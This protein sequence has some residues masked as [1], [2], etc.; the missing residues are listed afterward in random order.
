MREEKLPQRCLCPCL[1]LL[2]HPPA[3]PASQP[4][5]RFTRREGGAERRGAAILPPSQDA[6]RNGARRCP[7]SSSP[8]HTLLADEEGSGPPTRSA[9]VRG[10]QGNRQRGQQRKEG[11]RPAR[12]SGLF[13]RRNMPRLPRNGTRRS[14]HFPASSQSQSQSNTTQHTHPSPL[15][16]LPSWPRCPDGARLSFYS[17]AGVTPTAE[18][19]SSEGQ[20]GGGR[21]RAPA[22]LG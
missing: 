6:T 17:L 11:A 9:S 21:P 12:P 14:S 2:R 7:Q 20:A 13:S 8:K 10:G 1:A 15:P 19:G 18:R 5:G 4:A 16:R 3:P 22:N